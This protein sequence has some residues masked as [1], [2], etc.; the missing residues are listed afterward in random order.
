[1]A[2]RFGKSVLPSERRPVAWYSPPVLVQAGRELVSSVDFLRNSD[3]RELFDGPF[4]VIDFSKEPD[5]YGGFD[6]IADTG[7]GGNATFTVAEGAQRGVLQA[8]RKDSKKT[9]SFER[10]PLL[11]LG[12]DLAYP[13]ANSHDYHYRL[14]EPFELARPLA[15][16]GQPAAVWRDVV[17]IPQNHD[18][19]DSTTTFCRYFVDRSL[20]ADNSLRPTEFVGAYAR[21]QRTYFA[22]L[23][24]HRW[25]ILGLDLALKGDV[26]RKQF[27]DFCK[28][29]APE[30]KGPRIEPGDNIILLY[31]EPYWTRKLSHGA[32]EGYTMRYQRLEYLL[33]GAAGDT[34]E[35]HGAQAR[36]RLRLCGDLHHYCRHSVSAGK[37]GQNEPTSTHLVTCGSGGAFMHTTH[38]AEVQDEK[39]L[40]RSLAP[41]TEPKS[42]GLRQRVGLEDKSLGGNAADRTVFD[43]T[44]CY[45]GVQQSRCLALTGMIFSIIGR[46]NLGWPRPKKFSDFCAQIWDSNMGFAL[47][48]GFLYGFNAYANSIAFSES[49]WLDNFGP[50]RDY[51]FEPALFRDWLR[52]MF[53]SPFATLVN[54][55]MIIGC[56]RIAWEGTWGWVRKSLSGALHVVAHAV[57]VCLIYYF[58][59]K[60]A[61]EIMPADPHSLYR[62]LLTWVIVTVLGGVAGAMI[63]GAYFAIVNGFFGQLT[64]NASGAIAWQDY[65]GF[66]RFRFTRDELQAT[67]LA[68]DRVPR[69]W[70]LGAQGRVEPDGPAPQWHVEDEFTLR[71][72]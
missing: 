46:P 56:M 59:A 68:C 65:K 16:D 58:A 62:G 2:V 27:R 21:Q 3:R 4:D 60:C 23:L 53:F 34:R 7:D 28:L 61:F 26:D 33:E 22:T 66:L 32:P 1:M 70:K 55:V 24:P 13:T 42:L 71:H 63:F 36:I 38:G 51:G 39:I 69:K 37:Y 50:I 20:Q 40:D 29:W 31:P 52:A 25:W 5:C 49:F 44:R 57:S 43:Q 19:F 11:V 67:Y 54:L 17:A 14:L 12:G 6:F 8:I 35:T 18:W 15:P 9:D 48:L 47:C 10:P 72:K 45:P 41:D 64:N 30:R